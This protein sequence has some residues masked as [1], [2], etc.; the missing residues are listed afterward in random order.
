MNKLTKDQIQKIV[1]S[2]L[3]MCF[4]IYAYF[5]F[6]IGPLNTKATNNDAA[7]AALDAQLAQAKT[8]ILRAR[9]LQDEAR[10]AGETLAQINEQIPEGAPIAWFPPRLRA[11]FDR[12][13]IKDVTVKIGNAQ[14][15][16]EPELAAFQN[17]TWVVDVP[18]ANFVPL[19]IALAGLENEEMLLE[20]NRLQINMTDNLESQRITMNLNTLLK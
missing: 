7:I 14:R 9:N 19:S 2:S 8:K 1:L 6:L 4:L 17:V 15:A 5:T 20:I 10:K 3:L 12:H 13:N 18:R 11:F 16:T